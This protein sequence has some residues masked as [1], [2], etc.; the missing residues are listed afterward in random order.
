MDAHDDC[1]YRSPS[2]RRIEQ[3]LARLRQL[4]GLDESIRSAVL[5]MVQSCDM[6]AGWMAPMPP[7]DDDDG[8]DVLTMPP[9]PALTRED[10]YRD[11]VM[12]IDTADNEELREL[13][14]HMM[15][16]LGELSDQQRL[17]EAGYE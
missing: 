16:R 5:G 10:H 6:A 12:F 2:D 8:P 15:N 13:S 3:S 1:E 7:D 17:R 11:T 4:A 9:P 14:R